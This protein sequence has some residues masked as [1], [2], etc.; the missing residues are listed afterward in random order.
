MDWL[1]SFSELIT[2]TGEQVFGGNAGCCSGNRCRRARDLC[3][4][5]YRST[6]IAE[7]E[8]QRELL[9]LALAGHVVVIGLR[10]VTGQFGD[11]AVSLL[12]FV[13]GNRARCSLHSATI[14]SFVMLESIAA[15]WDTYHLLH[16]V[17][18]TWGLNFVALPFELNLCHNLTVISALLAPA[19]EA[20]G[21]QSA[22]A[23][24]I[25]PDML[26]ERC[27]QEETQRCRQEEVLVSPPIATMVSQALHNP[28]L[29]SWM[30]S[31]PCDSSSSWPVVPAAPP[32]SPQRSIEETSN[33]GAGLW[34]PEFRELACSDCGTAVCRNQAWNGTGAY[35]QCVYCHRCWAA[36]SRLPDRI[37]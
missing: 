9:G 31:Y 30:G 24:M 37:G 19:S 15:A 7:L 28:W 35:S 21:V 11:A 27:R 17:V 16:N 1:E 14:S 34:L 18:S 26:F 2:W 6:N 10:V 36:W 29:S 13:W 20:L 32:S 12:V 22:L 3:L 5:E 25:T 8:Q 23:S 4:P 33:V